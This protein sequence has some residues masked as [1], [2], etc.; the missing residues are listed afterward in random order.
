V[1]SAVETLS[2]TRVRLTV[3]VPFEELTPALESAYRRIAAQVQLPGFRKGRVPPRLID[4]RFG[5]AL[6]LEEAV[7]EAVP[8]FYTQSV[9]DNTVEALG[10]PDINVTD[11]AD[12]TDLKFTAEVDVRPA[13]ELPE[14]DSLEVTVE[15]AIVTDE[16]VDKQLRELQERF[17]TLVG[18]DRSAQNGDFVQIDLVARIDGEEI[19]DGRA[20]GMSFEIGSKS[21]VAGLDE[22]LV[23]LSAGEST[24]FTTQL[25]GP[26]Q[27]QD[28]EVEVSVKSVRVRELPELDDEFAQTASEFDTLNELSASLRD[29]LG[30]VK[31][32]EQA[33]QARDRALEALLA[34]VDLPV[35]ERVLEQEVDAR[36]EA[37]EEQL[38]A[39]GMSK[40]LFLD[41][42]G[43]TEEAFE[44]DLVERTRESIAAQLVLE[45]VARKEQLSVSEPEL[46]EQIVRRA[47]RLGMSPDALAQQIV[48][49][50]E[51]P[52]LVSEVV[53][54]KAL[55]LVVESA[56]IVD[57][58]GRPVDLAALNPSSPPS[59]DAQAGED[60]A[61]EDQEPPAGA[62]PRAD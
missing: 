40:Q 58:A 30:R 59:G 56:K 18:A 11:F 17:S 54:A 3:E 62:E 26:H 33:A 36:L 23:G 22:A 46:S 50:G 35:P 27:G 19:E 1:K 5:R 29:R 44:A 13:I 15:D 21:L 41:S 25:V 45:A 49:A 4:Q 7:N 60:Q 53:R 14:F 61:G 28:A 20:T 37:F 55:N 42:E 31:L 9:Q 32:M 10:T 51:V 48:Q 38:S 47:T 39:A 12:G 57:A 6:V 43:K 52:S 34:R 8:R 24:T 2:P 16:D